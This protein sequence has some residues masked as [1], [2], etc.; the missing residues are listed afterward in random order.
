MSRLSRIV[1]VVS[2]A[3]SGST[4]L[5]LLVSSHSDVQSVGEAKMFQLEPTK[6][7]TCGA[8]SWSTCEFWSAVDETMRGRGGPGLDGI[9]IDSEDADTFA[10][11][12]RLFFEAVSSVS[13]KSVVL[14]SSK[15]LSRMK[16]LLASDLPTSVIHLVRHPC[17]VVYSNVRKGSRLG[18][19]CRMYVREHLGTAHR[20]LGKAPIRV[21]YEALASRPAEELERIMEGLG[22]AF[23]PEQLTG[24]KQRERHNF[25]GNRMRFD[26]SEEIRLDEAW[27]NEL[28]ARLVALDEGRRG[29]SAYRAGGASTRKWIDERR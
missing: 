4:L 11:H 20:L 5:D 18:R 28:S 25:G 15:D 12:N 7:C 2:R 10:H 14:D 13:G 19:E 8:P 26:S 6:R 27:R 16:R 1:Y 24:W 23:E 29:L 3:H 21:R 9:A 22:L 17:G